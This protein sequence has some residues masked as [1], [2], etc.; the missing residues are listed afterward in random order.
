[1]ITLQLLLLLV[2]DTKVSLLLAENVHLVLDSIDRGLEHGQVFDTMRFCMMV[3]E[4]WCFCA[5]RI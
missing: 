1:M 2:V 5:S 3:E 4:G